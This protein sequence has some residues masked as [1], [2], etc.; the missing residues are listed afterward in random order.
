MPLSICGYPVIN[1]GLQNIPGQSPFLFESYFT[2][3][4]LAE[5]DP[6]VEGGATR[7][8]D[9]PSVQRPLFRQASGL[10]QSRLPLG[11]ER[12][13]AFFERGEGEWLHQVRGDQSLCDGM[14]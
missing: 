7:L 10:Y 5:H 12:V 4:C 1:L 14:A 13:Q 11:P 6:R 2:R 8:L 9:P 3:A